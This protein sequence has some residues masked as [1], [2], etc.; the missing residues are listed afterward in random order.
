M[1]YTYVNTVVNTI[2]NNKEKNT[3]PCNNISY[4][5]K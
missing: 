3:Q 1:R 2:V 5:Y 4:S